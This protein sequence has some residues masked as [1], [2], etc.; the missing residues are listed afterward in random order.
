[1]TLNQLAFRPVPQISTLD[2]IQIVTNNNVTPPK[3][4][5]MVVFI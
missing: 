4:G 3:I 2:N 1:M 5:G